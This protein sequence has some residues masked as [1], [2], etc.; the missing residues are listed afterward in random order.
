MEILSDFAVDKG[1]EF[2]EK[3]LSYV[4]DA[5]IDYVGEKTQKI[6]YKKMFD[7]SVEF[8][9]KFLNFYGKNIE[10]KQSFRNDN[11]FK[12]FDK[13][14]VYS[15]IE[16]IFEKENIEK[17]LNILINQEI[18]NFHLQ[19]NCDELN[20]LLINN[21]KEL[22]N[23]FIEIISDSFDIIENNNNK[24]CFNIELDDYFT[25]LKKVNLI[26]R[27]DKNLNKDINCIW[28]F[29]DKDKIEKIENSLKEEFLEK[30]KPIIYI[31]QKQK[32][33]IKNIISL[34]G[35]PDSINFEDNNIINNFNNNIIDINESNSNDLDNEK[36]IFSLIKKTL[37]NI[38]INN[39][40]KNCSEK[41]EKLSKDINGKI[42]FYTDNKLDNILIL[43]GQYMKKIFS[44]LLYKGEKISAF[45]KFKYKELLNK[46]IEHLKGYEKSYFDEIKKKSED[47]Y[48][49]K[50]KDEINIININ[51]KQKKNVSKEDLYN[52]ELYNEIENNKIEFIQNHE[53]NSNEK[54]NSYAENFSS[55]LI[56]KFY[57]FFIEKSSVY[58]NELVIQ[59]IKETLIKYYKLAAIKLFV[60]LNNDEEIFLSEE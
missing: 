44:I 40:E 35:T 50:I 18:T 53:M 52:L 45:A 3:I 39:Y 56:S 43:N 38:L 59:I 31:Y 26:K 48:V 10:K 57:D 30:N 60:S 19:R 12:N 7:S 23:K 14:I 9:K 22:L 47:E 17:D 49:S 29:V 5:I 28:Y 37:F 34:S 41:A 11:V 42:N 4:S 58:I 8:G 36:Y 6:R 24:I 21:K 20:I 1:K 51:L 46:Y 27:L 15:I 2:L 32:I 16:E 25:E 54:E 13:N 33:N 55:Q